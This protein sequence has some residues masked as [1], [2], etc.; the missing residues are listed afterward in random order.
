MCFC[1]YTTHGHCGII[2]HKEENL[3]RQHLPEGYLLND[4][5]LKLLAKAS[6]VHAEAGADII[7]P[8]GMLDGMIHAIRTELDQNKL[9]NTMIMSYAAKYSSAFYG[10]F[11]QAAEGAPEFGD[12]SQYQM[13]FRNGD[14]ALK[15]VELD[16]EEGADIIICLLYTSP[17]PRDATL[18]RMPSSA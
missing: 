1:E 14:E 17:S 11:R 18:S 2:H 5:T 13:D 8:S 10:P 9:E 16:I 7:A 6:V 12:R 15:E 3:K 4:E